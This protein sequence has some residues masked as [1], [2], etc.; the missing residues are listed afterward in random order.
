MSC[1]PHPNPSFISLSRVRNAP[2]TPLQTS[3]ATKLNLPLEMQLPF[4][5]LTPTTP[6]S[7]TNAPSTTPNGPAGG[8]GAPASP[9]R[10]YAQVA[11]TPPRRSLE[12]FPPLGAGTRTLSPK[13]TKVRRRK[14]RT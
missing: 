3:L 10:T 12:G 14:Q 8:P 6:T 7:G 1:P 5:S 9:R 2:Q 11:T 13:A 4:N